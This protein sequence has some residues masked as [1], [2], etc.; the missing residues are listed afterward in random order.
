MLYRPEQELLWDTWLVCHEGT[1]YLFY[2]RISSSRSSS[3]SRPSLGDGWNGI[4]LAR[5]ADLLHWEEV[6]PVLEMH[7]DAAW[8]GTGM[9][10]RRDDD[11]VMT[12]CEE[13]PVGYSVI[14]FAVSRDLLHWHRLPD[15]YDLRPDPRFYQQ[16]QSESVD[17]LPRWGD[18][19]VVPPSD[20]RQEYLGFAVA[21]ARGTLPGHCGTLGLFR[22]R[23]GLSWEARPPAVAPGLYPSYEVPEYIRFGERHYVLFSTNSTAGPRFDPHA[24]GPHSG[25]YYVVSD[26]ATGP[27]VKPPHDNLLLG[28]RNTP[29][30]FGTYVGRPLRI[31][32]DQVLLYHQWTAKTPDGWWG[33]PKMLVERAPYQL[34]VDYWPGCDGL[35][36]RLLVHGVRAGQWAPLKAAGRVPVIDWS[37]ESNSMHAVN[38]GGTHGTTWRVPESEPS[39]S[40]TDLSDGR[41]IE[42][43]L[44]IREGRGLG[45]WIGRG[46]EADKLGLLVNAEAGAVEVGSFSYTMHGASL[47]FQP[48]ERVLWPVVLGAKH[49]LRVI[50]RRHFLE[51]YLDHRLAHAY[52][53]PEPLK[54]ANLG[55]FAELASGDFIAPTLWAMA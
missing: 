4:S 6:G 23:D 13:R 35:R 46:Q 54:P 15:E 29:R 43:D 12:F 18:L 41:V 9:V 45:I 40:Y 19:S 5:S 51:L 49:H 14:C 16:E 37:V 47:L 30:L 8:L 33:P 10:F 17:P 52:I 36:A 27:Y 7:S 31:S 1:Y 48:D 3:A 39:R 24:T 38:R 34:G 32:D 22:S 44:R 21:N 53:S 42:M 20:G 50:F 55:F 25:I 2:I 28:Q 26:C 11:F